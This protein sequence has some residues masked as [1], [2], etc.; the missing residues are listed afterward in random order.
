V[1][2]VAQNPWQAQPVR[3]LEFELVGVDAHERTTAE[4]SGTARDFQIHT[5]QSTPFQ[6]A[7]KPAGTETRFDLYYHYRFNE[8]FDTSAL[9]AGPPMAAP[10][11]FAQVQR[12][13]VRDVCGDTQHRAR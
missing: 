6:L 1:E 2:G 9:V 10:R 5:N 4:T 3:Y 13:L 12:F 11:L 8:E 7:L